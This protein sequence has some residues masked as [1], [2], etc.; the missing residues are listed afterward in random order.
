MDLWRK[1]GIAAVFGI[2]AI[3]GGGIAWQLAGNWQMVFVFLSFLGFVGLAFLL[4]PE[5]VVNEIVSK[6]EGE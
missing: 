3:I 1:I 5:M 4:N 2:A 6:D